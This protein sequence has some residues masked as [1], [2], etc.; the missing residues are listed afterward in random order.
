MMRLSVL[1]SCYACCLAVLGF[2]ADGSSIVAAQGTAQR[3]FAPGVLTT[4]PPDFEPTETVSTH[5]LVEIRANA[6]SKWQPEL[7]TDSR[8][9]YGMAEGVKFRRDISCL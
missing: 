7:M 6:D 9:L 1:R 3:E 4:I 2:L 8:T 5:D